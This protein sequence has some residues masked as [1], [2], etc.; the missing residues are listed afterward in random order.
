M[1][2]ACKVAN[3]LHLRAARF[4]LASGRIM[5][6]MVMGNRCG[7]TTHL[8]KAN[9][10]K[11]VH[12]ATAAFR[13]V[14]ATS[15]WANGATTWRVDLACTTTRVTPHT[16]GNGRTICRTVMGSRRGQKALATRASFTMAKRK[17]LAATTGLTALYIKDGG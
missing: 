12:L 13:T 2:A 4:T 8:M 17:D 1:E 9:G 16:R 14:T 10:R 3:R 11:T 7:L 5:F 15:S 6:A